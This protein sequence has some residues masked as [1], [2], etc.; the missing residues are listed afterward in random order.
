MTCPIANPK[1]AL[2]HIPC[3]L[4][5]Q[6]KTKTNTKTPAAKPYSQGNPSS[7]LK[8]ITGGKAQ[9][10]PV[11]KSGTIVLS[12]DKIQAQPKP[13][14]KASPVKKAQAK[15]FIDDFGMIQVAK[16]SGKDMKTSIWGRSPLPSL[17]GAK[18]RQGKH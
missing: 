16:M 2:R 5:A 7:S 10:K 8:L 12:E 17:S 4:K 9:A 18:H 3:T 1:S 14:V 13:A 11:A 6:V 15:K